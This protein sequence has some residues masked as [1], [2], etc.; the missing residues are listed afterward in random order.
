MSKTPSKKS[1]KLH[2]LNRSNIRN[3][4]IGAFANINIKKGTL[5]GEYKGN[6]VSKQQ[7]ERMRNTN[8]IFQVNKRGKIHHYIDGRRGNWITRINGAK[9]ALQVRKINVECYQY[10]QKIYYKAKKNIKKGE[11]F[12]I[13][14][15]D[16]YWI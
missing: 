4:G 10:G 13:Y 5:L 11:E 1:K 6:Y 12:I 7:F 15:G 3:A 16:E 8:Y 14:Y 2:L 9:T